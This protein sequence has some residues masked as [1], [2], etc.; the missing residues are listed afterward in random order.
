MNISGIR[1]TI[2]RILIS[3]LAFDGAVVAVEGLATDVRK[4]PGGTKT[5]F[6]LS[7]LRGNYINVSTSGALEILENDL[8]VV[9]GIYRR[10]ENEIEAEEVEKVQ[11]KE[12][13]G[14]REGF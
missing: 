10:T 3:P 4:E 9:G 1:T 6:K 7:D 5:T 14:K 8:L 13:E 11:L 2:S 12:K